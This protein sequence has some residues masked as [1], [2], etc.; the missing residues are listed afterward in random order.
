MVAI[1]KK[2]LQIHK[3]LHEILQIVSVSIFDQAPLKQLLA[4]TGVV[5]LQETAEDENHNLLLFK[6][7]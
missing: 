7:L 6:E 4:A 2:R 1:T 5:G 3:S